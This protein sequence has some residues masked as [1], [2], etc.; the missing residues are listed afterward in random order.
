MRLK[1]HH[2]GMFIYKPSTVY[3]NGHI[4]EEEW[5]WDVDT[6]SYI[7]LT[8][9]IKSIGYKAFKCLWYRHP[10][11][12]LCRGSKQL[13]CDSDILQLAEDVSR[14][15]WLKCMWKRGCLTNLKKS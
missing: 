8:K 5:G 7:D 12:A 10:L 3:V 15:M 4:V 2:G 11:K 14:L 9:V 13:N 1:I 6:M